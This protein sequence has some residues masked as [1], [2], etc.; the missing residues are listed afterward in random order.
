[1][2]DVELYAPEQTADVGHREAIAQQTVHLAQ[3]QQDRP[4]F[5]RIGEHVDLGL[6]D[7]TTR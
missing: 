2:F 5:H 4:W 3:R 1:M 6:E 7:L